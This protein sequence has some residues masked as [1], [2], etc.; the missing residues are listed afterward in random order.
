MKKLLRVA[1]PLLML[2]IAWTPALLAMD[3]PML[4]Q[5]APAFSLPT[6]AGDEVTSTD[7]RGKYIVLHFGAGW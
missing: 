4:G 1:T 5:E 7:L 3:H 2:T 6:L